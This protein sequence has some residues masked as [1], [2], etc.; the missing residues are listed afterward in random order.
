MDT[1]L[2]AHEFSLFTQPCIWKDMEI[3]HGHLLYPMK[4][5]FRSLVSLLGWFVDV[6]WTYVSKS[7][8]KLW[9]VRSVQSGRIPT[10]SS[11]VLQITGVSTNGLDHVALEFEDCQWNGFHSIKGPKTNTYLVCQNDY[12]C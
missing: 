12:I 7:C 8:I 6:C 5:L 10:F 1:K 3:A 2:F 9:K 11:I 4:R